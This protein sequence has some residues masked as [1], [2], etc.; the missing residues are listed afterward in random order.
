MNTPR[1]SLLFL[2][3]PALPLS[4]VALPLYV[5]WPHYM[6]TTYALSLSTLGFI[7]LMS[8]MFD[9]VSDPWIGKLTDR[10]MNHSNGRVLI[11]CVIASTSLSMGF[12]GIFNPDLLMDMQSP[13]FF[14]IGS[15]LLMTYLSYSTLCIA[16][17][18]WAARLGG[19]DV[20]R[21][22]IVA[23]REG[24]GLVGAITASVLPTFFGFNLLVGVFIALLWIAMMAWYRAPAP[25]LSS[26]RALTN[27]SH[28]IVSVW[29]DKSF[30][31]LLGVFVLNGISSA[32]SASLILFFIQD[33]LQLP[34]S[35]QGLFLA[36]YFVSAALFMP[37]WVRCVARFGLIRCWLM[38]ISL[39][40]LVFIWTLTLSTGEVVDYSLVCLLSGIALGADLIV[41]NA[42]LSG[43][44]QK[45]TAQSGQYLSWWQVATKFI[46][47]LAVSASLPLLQIMGYT[48]GQTDATGLQTLSLTY[49]LFPCVIKILAGLFLYFGQHHFKGETSCND[50]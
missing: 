21:S 5:Q 24:L 9:A 19:D 35:Y 49:G 39:A 30:I 23:W 47:A 15:V 18:A 44:I 12:A 28:S 2:G 22:R 13:S 27:E 14:L 41:P 37:L 26:I 43:L 25:H 11:A 40:V 16:Q 34:A 48:P 6:A 10:W 36:L 33:R 17:Q 29:L 31:M 1:L 38:G 45:N 46:S 8:R 7:L 32:I 20:V 42:L 50:D 4:F 3:L